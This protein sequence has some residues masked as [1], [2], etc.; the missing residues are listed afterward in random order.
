MTLPFVLKIC[1]SL[2]LKLSPDTCQSYQTKPKKQHGGWFRGLRWTA[3][4]AHAAEVGAAAAEVLEGVI[5]GNGV[6]IQCHRTS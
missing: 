6:V 3:A 2:I 1:F 4:K 5:V